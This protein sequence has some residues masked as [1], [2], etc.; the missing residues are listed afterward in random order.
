M[1]EKLPLEILYYNFNPEHS[2]ITLGTNKGF[3]VFS[4]KPFSE[5]CLNRGK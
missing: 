2:C 1:M 3:K 4:I 5:K